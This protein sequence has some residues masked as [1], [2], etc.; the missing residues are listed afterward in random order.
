MQSVQR[1][2]F[3][4]VLEILFF[5]KVSIIIIILFFIF[6]AIALHLREDEEEGTGADQQAGGRAH[7]DEG[8][9]LKRVGAAGGHPV[10][11]APVTVPSPS[12]RRGGGERRCCV[13]P[14]EDPHQ[15]QDWK[16]EKE[17]QR[18]QRRR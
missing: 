3:L 14:T 6:F 7:R 8:A 11:S 1:N 2:Y 13:H 18:R 16:E 17:Q 15:C 12:G 5:K 4:V 10:L 9:G